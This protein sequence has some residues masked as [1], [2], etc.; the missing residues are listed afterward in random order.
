M[1]RGSIPRQGESFLAS[2]FFKSLHL[3]ALYHSYYLIEIFF[4]WSP[5]F[6]FEHGPIRFFGL[7][8]GGGNNRLSRVAQ[9]EFCNRL[10]GSSHLLQHRENSRT[11][12]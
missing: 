12:K 10:G 6:F 5:G 2:L 11:T 9:L 4:S 7:S 8:P 3:N 1:D